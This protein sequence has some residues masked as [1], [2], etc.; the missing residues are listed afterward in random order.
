[1]TRVI[2]IIIIDS[3][4]YRALAHEGVLSIYVQEKPSGEENL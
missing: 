3:Y 2:I 1:V 4:T